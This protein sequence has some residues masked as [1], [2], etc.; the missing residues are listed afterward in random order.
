MTTATKTPTTDGAAARPQ[1]LKQ[2]QTRDAR[3]AARQAKLQS[4]LAKVRDERAT[5]KNQIKV[6]REQ[7]KQGNG[8]GG[9]RA[10]SDTIRSGTPLGDA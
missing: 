8:A 1:T 2:M 4:D 10:V 6:A 7:A 5:L 3:L 9:T